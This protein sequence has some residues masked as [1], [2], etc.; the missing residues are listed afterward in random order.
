MLKLLYLDHTHSVLQHVSKR[1]CVLSLLHDNL[2]EMHQNCQFAV[3]TNSIQSE[4]FILDNTHAL[5][6]NIGDA[7]LD[8]PDHDKRNATYIGPC[9]VTIPCH[10]CLLTSVYFYLPARIE[11]CRP[12][13]TTVTVRHTLN[14]SFLQNFFDKKQ[15]ADIFG[16]T[17]LTKPLD[18]KT[19]RLKILEANY[20]HELEIDKRVKLDLVRLANLTKHDKKAFP[21]LAY[22][23]VDSWKDFSSGSYD[24]FY[25]CSVGVLGLQF[26]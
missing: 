11:N 20:S 18:V 2:S 26:F 13:R 5:L 17:T 1:S 6:T 4:I 23:M 16:N 9:G 8:C 19:P 24:W 12:D 21:S 22:S 14:L 7:M 15:L 25:H 3:V 10:G